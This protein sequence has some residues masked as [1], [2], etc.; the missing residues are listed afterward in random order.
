MDNE[1]CQC[2][3]IET[4]FVYCKTPHGPMNCFC[5]NVFSHSSRRREGTHFLHNKST[6]QLQLHLSHAHLSPWTTPQITAGGEHEKGDNL[7][8]TI[9]LFQQEEI[10]VVDLLW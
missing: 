3:H 8:F 1:L 2:A 4:D 5:T 9:A 10:C 7:F 6:E